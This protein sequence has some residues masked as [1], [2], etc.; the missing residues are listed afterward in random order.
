MN[1]LKRLILI[2]LIVITVGLTFS[3]A[4][5]GLAPVSV[6]LVP[7]TGLPATT[8]TGSSYTL[9]YTLTNNLPSPLLINA[10]AHT[11]SNSAEFQIKD[12][13]CTN[14]K[15]SAGGTCN[16]TV[17]FHGLAEGL[18]T[19]ELTAR[20]GAT[21]IRLLP[22]LSTTVSGGTQANITGS[23]TSPL[24]AKS[25]TSVASYHVAFTFVNHTATAV[26]PI[27]VTPT[28]DTAGLSDIDNGCTG[29]LGTTACTYSATF[30]PSA[31]GHTAVGVTYSY[32]SDG[33][34]YEVPLTSTTIATSGGNCTQVNGYPS[35]ALPS[36]AYQY[37]DNVVQFK[38][39]NDCNAATATL[40][41]V[42]LAATLNGAATTQLT[43][44]EDSC[45]GQ[46][47]AA[48]ASCYVNASIVPNTDGS[49]LAVSASLP[50][51]QSTESKTAATSTTAT[52][53]AVNDS[54]NRMVTVVN[55]CSHPVWMAFQPGS[56]ATIDGGSCTSNADCPAAT[57]CNTESGNCYWSNPSLDGSHPNGM[58]VAASNNTAPD[59]MNI[60]IA[61]TN[62]EASGG[63]PA[64]PGV[65]LYNAGIV[66]RT[67]C[68]G[69]GA[70]NGTT[71]GVICG[72]NT[73]AT[74]ADGLCVPGVG[75]ATA[76]VAFNAVEMTFNRTGGDGVY[77]LQLIDGINI[78]IEMKGR[79]N[80]GAAPYD[81]CAAIGAP[82][83]PVDSDP[84][85]ALGAC[86]YDFSSEYPS[87]TP[88]SGDD[89]SNHRYVTAVGTYPSNL[90]NTNADCS[91][92][93]ICGLSY[94]SG[95]NSIN[96]TCG[97]LQGYVSVNK[98]ICSQ[99]NL[100]TGYDKSGYEADPKVNLKTK[101]YDDATGIFKCD[102]TFTGT[103]LTYSGTQLYACTH[104]PLDSCYNTGTNCC[105]CANWWETSNGAIPVPQ[106]TTS[107]GNN[108]NSHWQDWAKPQFQWVKAA[109]PTAYVYQY[110]DKSSSFTCS[111][112]NDTKVV[113]NY[114]ITFCS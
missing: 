15:L 103:D 50:Y 68:T 58:L 106:A 19:A 46:S 36:T 101:L 67:N 25:Q 80:V 14:V 30:T 88:L 69:T 96:K 93:T 37:G 54:T 107:C 77:D 56:V 105:G 11:F 81:N 60:S 109:C 65:A 9:Q 100:L 51:T 84:N 2:S 23:V 7:A 92:G 10:I 34:T 33:Q 21:V 74:G 62:G 59:T 87:V 102:Q 112:K 41:T 43:A 71:S 66:G 64:V 79:G 97:T 27:S 63:R 35:L 4:N 18:A 16:V 22:A 28:G 24:P 76:P 17:S 13:A 86:G 45:S 61:E 42:A 73:C 110:D 95:S 72:V 3:T 47:L 108:N 90:C 113:T 52:T 38:Y 89:I 70:G 8:Q 6:A 48:H 75:A 82:I 83:Q 114:Q 53:V 20:Y 44:G 111:V 91:G 49:A 32:A 26:T 98:G 12:D 85:T 31:A 5:A 39:T 94:N 104:P 99:A 55:Q 40:G 57:S 29:D 78:P 1:L